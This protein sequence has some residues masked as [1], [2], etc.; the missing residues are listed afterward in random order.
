MISDELPDD[1]Q[2]MQS[3]ILGF[4]RKPVQGQSE[5]AALGRV[6]LLGARFRFSR[7]A[8]PGLARPASSQIDQSRLLSET[9][10]KHLRRLFKSFHDSYSA[11]AELRIALAIADANL[12]L[13]PFDYP[14]LQAWIKRCASHLDAHAQAWV[15]AGAETP[16]VDPYAIDAENWHEYPPAQRQSFLRD[17]HR[18]EPDKALTLLSEAFSTESA[19]VR[20]R[21]LSA[22]EPNV[23]ERE[24]PFLVGLMQDRA[25][26]VVTAATA[27]LARIPGTVAFDTR[28]GDAVSSLSMRSTGLLRRA[29]TLQVNVPANVHEGVRWDWVRERF[30]GLHPSAFAKA[31]DMDMP[32]LSKAMQDRH[33]R[34]LWLVEALQAN[35]LAL[36]EMF[37]TDLNEDAIEALVYRSPDTLSDLTIE[38]RDFAMTVFGRPRHL[39]QMQRD[40]AI[41]GQLFSNLSTS[42]SEESSKA[43]INGKAMRQFLMD[44]NAV[45]HDDSV[46]LDLVGLVH[47]KRRPELLAR[48]AI[49]PKGFAAH[50]EMLS[51]LL[52]EIEQ[53][54]PE[55]SEAR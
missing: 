42:L 22:L 44:H 31:L 30:A 47:S 13:H 18:R 32:A 2:L 5:V 20:A 53:V 7:A 10:R 51:A 29:K 55:T 26:S 35:D 12:L 3:L 41:L 28:L 11:A 25:K 39:V 43:L 27:L 46:L 4:D 21:L 8:P 33:L 9:A 34:I 40:V 1:A 24:E 36:A 37:V 52:D 6:A 15:A 48:F 14:Y 49:L 19:A 54:R 16:D 45:H 38:A 50:A 17:L 23:S